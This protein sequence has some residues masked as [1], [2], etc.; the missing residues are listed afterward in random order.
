MKCG[1]CAF[2]RVC[3]FQVQKRWEQYAETVKIM[4]FFFSHTYWRTDKASS[5]SR[6]DFCTTPGPAEGLEELQSSLT[7]SSLS[8]TPMRDA[9]CCAEPCSSAQVEHVPSEAGAC[10][11]EVWRD[12]QPTHRS[13][14]PGLWSGSDT[15]RLR[16][17]STLFPFPLPPFHISK[18]VSGC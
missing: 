1:L 10:L 13:T 8:Y 6:V 16:D 4:V 15:Y 7:L 14:E 3:C 17:S 11:W 18:R 9:R 5:R 2:S 12:Q